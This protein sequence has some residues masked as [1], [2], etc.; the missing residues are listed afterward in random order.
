VPAG[1]GDGIGKRTRLQISSRISWVESPQQS[2]PIH[3]SGARITI[4]AIV[5]A[6]ECSETPNSVKYT[7][8]LVQIGADER[9]RGI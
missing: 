3:R 1:K 4:S 2:D 9:E 8:P 6:A 5:E 7:Y